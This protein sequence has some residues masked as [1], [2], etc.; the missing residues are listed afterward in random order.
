MNTSKL[1]GIAL[2]G[3][4][5]LS[6]CY[7]PDVVMHTT[8][9]DEAWVPCER[10]ITYSNVMPKQMRD[11]LWKEVNVKWSQPVPECLNTDA[12]MSTH[13]EI[14][15]DDTVST[16]FWTPFKSIDEMSQQTPLQLNGTRLRSE[17][18]LKKQFRWFY[19]KYV[20]SETFFCVGDT[21]QLADTLYADKDLVRY[22]FTGE[23]NLV[24]GMSGAEASQKL[25]EIEPNI[26]RW[27]NDNLLKVGF[28]FIVGHYDSI[29]APPVSKERFVELHDTLVRFITTG[30]DDLLDIKPEEKLRD[31]FHS[32]AYDDFFNNETSLGKGLTNELSKQL[33]IFGFNVPYLLTM[34]GKVIDTG[35][36]VL[37]PDGSIRYTFTGERLIPKDYTITATSHVTNI[38]AYVLTLVACIIV[39]VIAEK[40]KKK[41]G[42]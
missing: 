42:K 40:R 35:N 24:K 2:A 38:W 19:T 16:T 33:N 29:P 21:F 36:G 32:N 1:L 14:G 13:T 6:S 9:K 30:A 41:A 8:I 28:D 12:F 15:K 31:F 34:P 7:Q 22:W 3:T 18:K 37:Q 20:F 39:A 10:K 17:A 25:S 26:N 27:L 5:L 23:P 11:S 4:L